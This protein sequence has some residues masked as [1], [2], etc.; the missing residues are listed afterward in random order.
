MKSLFSTF[1]C[2]ALIYASGSAHGFAQA[3]NGPSASPVP[4]PV[5]VSTPAV[6]AAATAFD[7]RFTAISE[8]STPERVLRFTYRLWPVATVAETIVEAGGEVI[9]SR[10]TPYADNAL[11]T[12]ALLVLVD[13][14]VGQPQLPRNRTIEQNK[15]VIEDLANLVT[16]RIHLGVYGFAN[17]LV[18]V[19]PLGSTPSQVRAA[20]P[21]LR[22]EGLGTRVALSARDAIAKL[23][24]YD[25]AERKALVIF[26][27][28]K[29]EDTGYNW[30]DLR[31]AAQQAGI[32][33]FA[34]GCP[35]RQVDIPGL[36][37]L[38]RLAED[39][40]GFYAQM[41]LPP[42]G[43]RGGPQNP[44]DLAQAML[45]SLDGGGD[46]VASLRDQPT[47][48]KIVVRLKTESG[49]ILE[50]ELDRA[51]TAT[52]T[53]TPGASPAASAA[54]SPAAAGAA[55]SSAATKQGWWQTLLDE[56][57]RMWLIVAAAG[58]LF[59]GLLLIRALTKKRG[60]E[61][62]EIERIDLSD[63][64][65]KGN[66]TSAARGAPLAYLVL[67]DADA[68]RMPVSK[69]AT[70]IGRRSDND[71]VFSNDSV[72]GHH[73]EI[74]MGRDGSFTITDLNS[75]NGVYVNGSKVQQSGLRDGDSVEL[76]EVRFRF[77]L[78]R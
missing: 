60:P 39:T 67:Q 2:T 47:D 9:P 49:Q 52:A 48:A 58:V 23:K 53:P 29:D 41:N 32:M 51:V 77:S 35:E 50:K 24:A 62:A 64:A 33:V 76:G 66:A 55:A 1:S 63:D 75:G 18:E 37:A 28:A 31:E 6:A 42:A 74:H 72:S 7:D 13:T 73:A 17:D 36:G 43:A 20:L 59:A 45:E 11:N 10:A 8:E 69:T 19:A 15:K 65:A 3:T 38:Q 57:N 78:D 68:T 40:K 70:R 46:V 5:A 56:K 34:V 25:D 12:S 26:S 61:F 4:S 71:I 21:R 54:T 14:S 30:Q 16:P 44:P 22:A 27:D